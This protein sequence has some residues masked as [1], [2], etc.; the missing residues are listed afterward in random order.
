MQPSDGFCKKVRNKA[1]GICKAPTNGADPAEHN[2]GQLENYLAALEVCGWHT[3]LFTK[4]GAELKTVLIQKAKED[5]E[6]EAQRRQKTEA[7]SSSRSDQWKDKDT[8]YE[9]EPEL[10]AFLRPPIDRA[11]VIW[12]TF[13][14]DQV[15]WSSR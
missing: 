6:R 3:R 7:P 8:D 10:D 13:G 15:I 9:P 4:T 2:I 11:Q 1:R 5:F 14:R 12:P